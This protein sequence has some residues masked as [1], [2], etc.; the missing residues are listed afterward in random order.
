MSFSVGIFYSVQEFIEFVRD[1]PL[2]V[3]EFESTFT[4]YTLARPSDILEVSTKCNWI[5]IYPDGICR[6]TEK[7][8]NILKA[9]ADESLRVQLLDLIFVEQPDWAMKIP[10][11]RSEAVQFF[12]P[13][14]AQCFR[15]A[16]LLGEW[17]DEIIGW[18]DNLGIATRNS[19]LA[20]NLLTGR[21]AEKLTIEFEEKRTGIKPNWRSL[22]SNFSGYDILSRINKTDPTPKK[23]EVKGTTLSVKEAFF[24]LSRN[25]WEVAETSPSYVFHLWAMKGDPHLGE[26]TLDEMRDHIPTNNGEGKWET[27]RIR[28]KVFS[29]KMQRV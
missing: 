11:G 19:K 29:A 14:V 10:T 28:F 26:V 15:E 20:I 7:G 27:T 1:N 22:E 4:R 23:I 5:Q 3:E 17:N 25:E 18:W 12:P 21:K 13:E 9:S 24:T 8:R 2:S 16:G 6:I